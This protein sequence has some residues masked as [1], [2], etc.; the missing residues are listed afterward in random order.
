METLSVSNRGKKTE[1]S[2]TFTN[3]TKRAKPRDNH[4][5]KQKSIHGRHAN[6]T[7]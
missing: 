6:N 5:T 3:K 1:E 4:K 7:T 2:S